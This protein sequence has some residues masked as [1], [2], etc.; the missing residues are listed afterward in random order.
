MPAPIN[1]KD[2]KAAEK[3]KSKD[4][5]RDPT[6][7][8]GGVAGRDIVGKAGSGD[9]KRGGGGSKGGKAAKRR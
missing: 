2:S 5:A 3:E 4:K 6:K 7:S 9:V 8:K 1:R